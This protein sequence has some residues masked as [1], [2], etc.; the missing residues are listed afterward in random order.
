MDRQMSFKIIWDVGGFVISELVHKI[1]ATKDISVLKN[2]YLH[3][4]DKDNEKYFF[5]SENAPNELIENKYGDNYKFQGKVRFKPRYLPSDYMCILSTFLILEDFDF[6]LAKY[7]SRIIDKNIGKDD[8]IIRLLYS[9]HL[10][11]YYKISNPSGKVIDFEK[12][13]NARGKIKREILRIIEDEQEFEKNLK[14][15]KKQQMFSQKRA[16]CSLR[17]FIKSK[18][19]NGYFRGAM[20][21]YVSEEDI[22]SLENEKSLKQFVLPGDVWNNNTKFKK[23]ILKSTHYEKS[24]NALNVILYEYFKEFAPET[25]YPEQFD[26]TFDFVPRMCE[27]D[28]CCI[29]PINVEAP[30][31]FQK[32]CI[33]EAN[34]Y[35]TVALCACNYKNYC[36]GKERCKLWQ[37]E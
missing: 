23:C 31:S 5:L 36:I 20:L 34:K 25:G 32:I 16:W 3:K 13:I 15:F 28:N 22:C 30:D 26:I 1:K 12:N 4:D 14:T 8:I 9:L 6:S 18:E 17:D 27:K 24:K 7:I 21:E 33:N 37:K 10:L 19:F 2:S 29:C 35:C 11:T